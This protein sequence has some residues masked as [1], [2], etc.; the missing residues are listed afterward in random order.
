MEHRAVI[1]FL[2]LEG[3]VPSEVHT[4]MLKVYGDECPSYSTIK[5]WAA[6]FKSGRTSLDDDP[7]SGRPSTAVNEDSI[8]AVETCILE[9]R[10]VTIAELEQETGLSHGSILTIIHEHLGMN[11][12]SARWVPKSL[13]AD[14]KK[15]RHDIS[16][17]NLELMEQDLENFKLR[18]VTGDETWVYHY[19]PESKRQSMEWHHPTSPP[20]KKF[21]SSRS[22]KKVMATVFWDAKGI[23]HVDYLETQK[24]ITGAYYADLLHRLRAS[25]KEKRRGLLS[26]GVL[27]LHDNAS[28]HTS[29]LARS[30]VHHCGFEELPHPPYSPDLAPSDFHLFPKLKEHLRG[31]RY[32]DNEELK[33]AVSQYLT[34][35][36]EEFFSQGI[37]KLKTRY[38]KCIA[39]KGDYVEK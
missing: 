16:M 4:R 5:R 6:L 8:R 10:R 1:K 3:I 26:A 29:R 28:S 12:V 15:K 33:T 19:D 22:V 39:I 27:L 20:P 35:L 7:R 17:E 30:A 31:N 11:K 13:N 36:P 34:G 2:T 23:I 18:V 37:G 32:A 9:D 21:K 14:L 38:E 25:I 24:T